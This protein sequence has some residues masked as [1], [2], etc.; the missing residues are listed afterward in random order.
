MQN[1]FYN[2]SQVVGITI[3]HSLW[4]G[5][6]VYFLLKIILTAGAN[7]TASKKYLLAMAGL[8]GITSWFGYTL[9]NEINIYN[10]LAVTPAKNAVRPLLAE[11]PVVIG[12]FN[13]ESIR[14][15]YSIERYLPY[16]ALL[17]VLG[18]VF[19][20]VKLFIDRKKL[21][22]IKQRITF[23]APLQKSVDRFAG[24]LKI[25]RK[26]TSGLS[27]MIDVPCMV[28]YFKPVILLPFSFA[29]CMSAEEIEV[30]ILHELAHIKRN[31]YFL[32]ILQQIITVLLFFNPCVQL[33]NRIINEERENSCDDLVVKATA[34]PIIY[35]KALL[36]LEQNR[37][38]NWQLALAATGKKKHLLN[39]IERIMKTK[40]S[41]PSIRP[42]LLAMLILT[43]TIG[44][45]GLLKPEVAK[46]KI[47]VK[48]ISPVIH[49]MLADTGKKKAVKAKKKPGK[50]IVKTK[51]K[52][53]KD[54]ELAFAYDSDNRWDF[55]DP[56]LEKLS[57]EVEEHGNAISSY[58]ESGDFK[59][60]SDQLEQKGREMEAFYNKPELKELQE[61]MEKIG[62]D[63]EKNWGETGE[64]KEMSAKMEKLGKQIENYY[65]SKEFK[66]LNE[67]LEK[68]YGIPHDHQYY[69]DRDNAN[70]R[71]YQ[72]ELR[73]NIPAEVTRATDELKE[74]GNK[75]REHFHS[76]E[77][78]KQKELMHAMSDSLRH[79]YHNPEAEKQKEEMR[80]LSS[81]MREYSHNP[82]IEKE[83]KALHDASA[84]LRA[85]MN[86]PDFK[87]RLRDYKMTHP[88]KF[89][90]Y[91]DSDKNDKADKQEKAEQD[92]TDQQ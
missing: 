91:D 16:I 43:V 30:I 26:V 47:S 70:Y 25:G 84:R 66:T 35:A 11:L 62:A 89:H 72:A 87:K 61:K 85:Y 40:K 37:Q 1:L 79:A 21:N 78:E 42:T 24:A 4:Q 9:I 75:M 34:S 73:K 82:E 38:N 39:R 83:K 18:L 15:Y 29:A 88:E 36:K 13:D 2:I 68:K 64:V 3:I 41:I 49:Q 65:N 55:H 52:A 69:D 46:G 74:T 45:I 77:Y 60:L 20:T 33:I 58:Y 57:K 23:D 44:V 17:Y 90:W 67:S 80:E 12:K 31:D 92:S 28:G 27:K 59:K 56:Q 10:W 14:Y 50:E 76:P 54:A 63:F 48:A 8:L 71:N 6:T 22:D 86:T 19:N 7:L 5:L 51:Q 81:K 32:N 53:E